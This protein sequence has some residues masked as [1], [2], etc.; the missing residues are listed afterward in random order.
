MLDVTEE[1]VTHRLDQGFR[2]GG[3]TDTEGKLGDHLEGG[4]Y[5]NCQSQNPQILSQVGKAAEFFYQ[6]HH[7]AGEIRFLAADGIIHSRADDL[8]IEHICQGRHCGGHDRQQEIP[9][10]TL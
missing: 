2:G 5:N 7:K 6:R 3:V 1:P 10:G 9:L 4:D 8:G